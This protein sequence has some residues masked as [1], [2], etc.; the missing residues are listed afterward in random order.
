MGR[1]ER[2]ETARERLARLLDERREELGLEWNEVAQIAG[3]TKEGLR[4]ARLGPSVPRAKTK[5]GIERALR[6]RVG[7]F[8]EALGGGE[9]TPLPDERPPIFISGVALEANGDFVVVDSE[10]QVIATLQTKDLKDEG[11]QLLEEFNTLAAE[12]GYR[13]MPKENAVREIEEDPDL[14]DDLRA[15]FIEGYR[16]LRWEVA[17]AARKRNADDDS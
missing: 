12:Q 3:I 17:E 16:K 4:T 13:L 11:R 15:Q 10:G 1:V 2:T 14:P 5:R 7:A 9:L 6:L 8:D